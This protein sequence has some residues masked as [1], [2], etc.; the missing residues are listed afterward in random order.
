M[1]IW[2]RGLL[3]IVIT[4]LLVI[5][6]LMFLPDASTGESVPS[7]DPRYYCVSD[8]ETREHIRNLMFE[9]LDDALHDH[10]MHLFAI[11]MKDDKGQPGRARAGVMHGIIAHKT[12]RELA[13][14]WVP[15]ICE[16]K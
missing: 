4:V 10:F 3:V 2:A 1:P 7:S 9:A 5:L 16:P 11:W 13:A 12:A 6:L 8:V 14:A 15:P